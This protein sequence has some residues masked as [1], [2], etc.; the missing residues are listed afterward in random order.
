MSEEIYQGLVRAVDPDSPDSVHLAQFP[1]ADLSLVDEELMEAT[2]LAM[3]VSSM[4]RGARSK[5]GIK[6]RQPLPR[7]VVKTRSDSEGAILQHVQSQVLDEL[8]V[9][10]VD[11]D[12]ESGIYQAAAAALGEASEGVVQVDGLLGRS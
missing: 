11:R 10:T 8:N 4:G 2:R 9:K 1:V 7:V 12:G 5:A 3:R 6:V